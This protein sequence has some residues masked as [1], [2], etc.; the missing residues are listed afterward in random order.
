MVGEPLMSRSPPAA[1]P[2]ATFL[3]AFRVMALALVLLLAIFCA[4]VRLPVAVA[5]STVPL[6]VVMPLLLPTVPMTSAP[7]LLKLTLPEPVEAA[8]VPT[9]LPVALLST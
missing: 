4:T 3:A 7:L 6:V 9:L 5:T 1:L 2:A 8:S